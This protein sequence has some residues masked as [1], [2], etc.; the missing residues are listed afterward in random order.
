MGIFITSTG[1]NIGKT[2]VTAQ[3]LRYDSMHKNCLSASKPIVSGPPIDTDTL[4]A[5]QQI[6]ITTQ[7][8]NN[9][10]PWQFTAPLSPDMA[11]AQEGKSISAEALVSDSLQR[12][13]QAQLA[14]KTH[15]IEGV[16]GVMVPLQGTFT[17]LDWIARVGCPCILVV[18]SY[19]G[20]LSHTLTAIAVLR[21]KNIQIMAVVINE[22]P[23][24]SVVFSELCAHLQSLLPDLSLFALPY[25]ASQGINPAIASLYS[26]M[27]L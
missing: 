21:A 5:A 4:L 22:T 23:E 10:S 18:G 2:Y 1:T 20:T 3:L 15:L 11:A 26:C 9:I 8:R 13:Q 25:S 17:V 12:I 14:Q 24:S 7:N 27:T 6:C 16:G 19:L